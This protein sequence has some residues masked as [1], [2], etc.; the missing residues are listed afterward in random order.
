M[1]PVGKFHWVVEQWSIPE[2]VRAKEKTLLEE[3]AARVAQNSLQAE[4]ARIRI[5]WKQRK[6]AGCLEAW[7]KK[8]ANS[9]TVPDPG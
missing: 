8:R 5:K 7:S 6:Q 1:Q 3:R 2:G 4:S 9:L